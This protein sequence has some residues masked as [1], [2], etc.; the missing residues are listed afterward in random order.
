MGIGVWESFI[1]ERG[2]YFGELRGKWVGNFSFW[3]LNEE[4]KNGI[5]MGFCFNADDF[6]C[7]R[8]CREEVREILLRN[9][10]VRA[11]LS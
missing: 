3:L 11:F 7:R 6:V 5:V 1:Y 9:G 2:R 4:V 8:L 10:F